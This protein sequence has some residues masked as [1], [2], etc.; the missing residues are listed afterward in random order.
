MLDKNEGG[1]GKGDESPWG[2]RERG[3]AFDRRSVSGK[4][5]ALIRTCIEAAATEVSMCPTP[6]YE[7]R[8][9]LK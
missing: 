7:K 4:I 8:L 9:T 2:C 1:I 3:T 6:K 5:S